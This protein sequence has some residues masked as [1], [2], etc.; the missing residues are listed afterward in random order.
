MLENLILRTGI[1][2]FEDAAEGGFYAAQLIRLSKGKKFNKN[3]G[4]IWSSNF[5]ILHELKKTL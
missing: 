2:Q 5:L 4:P 1:K 3:M